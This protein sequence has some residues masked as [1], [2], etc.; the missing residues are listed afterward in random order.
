M[1]GK[2][3]IM[4][5]ISRQELIRG[6]IRDQANRKLRVGGLIKNEELIKNCGL[7][8]NGGVN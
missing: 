8:M 2:G 7:I 3:L 4:G 1:K 6:L 5:L